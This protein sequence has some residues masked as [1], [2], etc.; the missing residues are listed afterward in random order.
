MGRGA[1]SAPAICAIDGGIGLA[2]AV[3]IG[4]AMAGPLNP[5][6][7]GDFE[8]VRGWAIAPDL[9]LRIG[10]GGGLFGVIFGFFWVFAFEYVYCFEEAFKAFHESIFCY[11]TSDF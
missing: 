4:L 5:P 10:L 11:E 8:S 1:F 6:S 9:L 3:A 7:L 2:I